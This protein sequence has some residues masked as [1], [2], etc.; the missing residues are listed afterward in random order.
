[1]HSQLRQHVARR[2]RKSPLALGAL[3][4]L[5]AVLLSGCDRKEVMRF[6]WPEGITPQAEHMRTLWTWSVVAALVVGVLVWALIFWCVVRYRKRGDELPTQTRF[7]APLEVLYTLGPILIVLV[8][9][10]YTAVTQTYV[11][12]KSKVPDVTVDVVAS[13]WNW[14]FQYPGHQTTGPNPTTVSTI[15]S[16]DRVPVLVV[17]IDKTVRFREHSLDVIHSFWVPELLF[18]RDV[19]P[20]RINSFEVTV[21]KIGH[22]VGHCAELCGAYHSTMNFEMRSVTW[23]KYQA[24]LAKL[25]SGASTPDALR[26]IGESPYATTTRPF[27][28]DRSVANPV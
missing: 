23:Q 9:F 8:L 11:D 28:T 25:Q 6:G 7:N 26:S 1:M 27:N 16:S 22:Y 2:G 10:Y 19:I 21:D 14:E 24:F 17:P 5:A 4:L 3:G 18:K 15:G 12:K 20:G 13:K